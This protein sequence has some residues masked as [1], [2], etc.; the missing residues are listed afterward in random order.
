MVPAGD[1]WESIAE[2]SSV[3]DFWM[4]FRRRGMGG[5]L[6]CGPVHDLAVYHFPDA[7]DRS[8]YRGV[9]A[10]CERG[11]GGYE[12]RDRPGRWHVMAVLVLG[13]RACAV[14]W[15]IQDNGS[16]SLIVT[17][18]A[19]RVTFVSIRSPVSSTT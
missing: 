11:S 2:T 14:G 19:G 8:G 13:R 7:A 9:Q 12:D 5:D 3:F 15:Q 4:R 18:L 6:R 16:G 1:G 10:L 17:N